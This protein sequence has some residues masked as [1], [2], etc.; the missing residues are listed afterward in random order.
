MVKVK[1]PILSLVLIV[2]LRLIL[3]LLLVVGCMTYISCNFNPQE[4][5]IF[6]DNSSRKESPLKNRLQEKSLK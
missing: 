5:I 1:C 4:D 2:V 6:I 3:L